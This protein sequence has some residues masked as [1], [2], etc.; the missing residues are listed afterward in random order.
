[1]TYCE[2]L[3]GIELWSWISY[4]VITQNQSLFLIPQK[5]EVCYCNI[6]VQDIY[7]QTKRLIDMLREKKVAKL[8]KIAV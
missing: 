1:M 6:R 2:I 4:N 7:S 5:V 8:P 3:R